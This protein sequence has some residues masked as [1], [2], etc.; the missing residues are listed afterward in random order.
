VIFLTWSLAPVEVQLPGLSWDYRNGDKTR[1]LPANNF[2]RHLVT[3]R[4]W[5]TIWNTCWL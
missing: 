2:F 3:R 4:L 5:I 1:S